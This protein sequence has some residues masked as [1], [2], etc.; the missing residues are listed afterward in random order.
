MQLASDDDLRYLRSL[1]NG[2]RS[3]KPVSSDRASAFYKLLFPHCAMVTPYELRRYANG[4]EPMPKKTYE[5]LVNARLG[6]CD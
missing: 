6:P 4:E 5:M 2:Q 3:D 1:I